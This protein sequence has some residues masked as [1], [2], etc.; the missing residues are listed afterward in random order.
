MKVE[1]DD[2][3]ARFYAD[4][5]DATLTFTCWRV[6]VQ[7]NPVLFCTA[8]IRTVLSTFPG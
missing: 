8:P 7:T 6:D 1:V 4:V 3:D 2:D 5:R